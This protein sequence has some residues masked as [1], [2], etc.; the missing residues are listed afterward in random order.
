M[1]WGSSPDP[2][3][4]ASADLPSSPACAPE[5]GSRPRAR[6][7][8]G[9]PLTRTGEADGAGRRVVRRDGDVGH[10]PT[11]RVARLRSGPDVGDREVLGQAR[12]G[13]LEIGLF[14]GPT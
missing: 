6:S 7:L 1:S 13:A 3:F 2:S 4:C 10:G 8:R 5:H 14:T 9:G 12:A 11:G